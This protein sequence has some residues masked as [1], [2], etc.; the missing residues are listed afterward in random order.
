[1]GAT[2]PMPAEDLEALFDSI[3][4]SRDAAAVRPEAAPVPPPA[5]APVARGAAAA[6]GAIYE[7]IGALTRILHDALRELGH[8]KIVEAAVQALP[9]ARERLGYI[10]RLTGQA[11]ERALAAV[12]QGKSV[13]ELQQREAA[14]LAA[15]WER[16]YAGAMDVEAF[17]ALAGRT[18]D[19]LGA[20]PERA[21][22]LNGCLLEVMMAQDFHDLTGQVVQRLVK[23]ARKLEEQLVALLLAATPAERRSGLNDEWLGGPS[24]GTGRTDV[25]ADQ[26]QVDQLLESLGF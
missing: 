6:E 16:V 10:S 2:E 24:L 13:Q 5:A 26:A 22:R 21:D 23:L 9:D 12:E 20:Q 1:M 11:A 17:K 7:R 25:A 8:D 19:F 4:A 3:A 18:R 14:Q 15:D